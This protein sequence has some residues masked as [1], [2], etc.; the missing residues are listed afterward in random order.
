MRAWEST[1][2]SLAM[3]VVPLLLTVPLR[4]LVLEDVKK[5]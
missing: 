4:A 5:P 2:Y 1:A 3:L